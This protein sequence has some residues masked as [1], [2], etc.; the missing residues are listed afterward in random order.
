MTWSCASVA[1][2]IRGT[3]DRAGKGRAA[4]QKRNNVRHDS[5]EQHGL[6]KDWTI[7]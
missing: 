4:W 1:G 5:T 2:L 3:D 7:A 6:A